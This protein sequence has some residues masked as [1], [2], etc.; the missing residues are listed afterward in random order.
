VI[1]E[2]FDTDQFSKFANHFGCTTRT[3]SQI[4][5]RGKYSIAN[6]TIA[7]NVFAQ[8]Q[9]NYGHKRKDFDYTTKI[10]EFPLRLRKN[11]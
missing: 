5:Y 11:I 9:G 10:K 3:I 2:N 4:W 1:K 6:G 8:I 7:A